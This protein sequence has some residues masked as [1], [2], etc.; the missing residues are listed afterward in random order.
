M[1]KWEKEQEEKIRHDG[2]PP[3]LTISEAKIARMHEAAGTAFIE[4]GSVPEEEIRC[5]FSSCIHGQ[6]VAGNGICPEGD[7]RD[8]ECGRYRQ[9]CPQCHG[10]GG[11]N[12]TASRCPSC[13]GWGYYR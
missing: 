13:G 3:P 9:E 10:D 6:G 11:W 8:E 5:P 7:P 12:G 2:T 4:S 1:E